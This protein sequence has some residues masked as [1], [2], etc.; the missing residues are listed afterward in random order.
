MT[1]EQKIAKIVTQQRTHVD[2]QEPA[3]EQPADVMEQPS[4]EQP[5]DDIKQPTCAQPADD[6]K[7]PA[8]EMM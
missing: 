3:H 6:M 7:Q 4:R 1:K 8:H 5:A 2:M